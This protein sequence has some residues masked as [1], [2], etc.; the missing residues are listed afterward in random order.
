MILKTILEVK[1][2]NRE[3]S[4]LIIDDKPKGADDH[5]HACIPLVSLE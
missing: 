1:L 5:L 3:I 2:N 4:E